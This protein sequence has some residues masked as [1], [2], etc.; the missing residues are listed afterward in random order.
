MNNAKFRIWQPPKVGGFEIIL[1]DFSL[2][3]L[4]CFRS[5]DVGDPRCIPSTPC[6]VRSLWRRAMLDSSGV[7]LYPAQISSS[8]HLMEAALKK[9]LV[10]LWSSLRTLI[11]QW[12]DLCG[13]HW[14]CIAHK[15][16]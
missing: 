2:G 14:T 15:N 5:R 13:V 10:C 6:W 4:P 11:C 12:F 3:I 9:E 7:A 8:G 1:V 16:N